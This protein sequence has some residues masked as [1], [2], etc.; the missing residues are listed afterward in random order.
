MELATSIL[1]FLRFLGIGIRPASSSGIQVFGRTI[2][3]LNSSSERS[4]SIKFRRGDAAAAFAMKL[5]PERLI[6]IGAGDLRHSI[7]FARAGI[8][9]TAVDLGSSVYAASRAPEVQKNNLKVIDA[10]F[11]RLELSERFEVLFCSH[12]LEHQQDVKAFLGK[13]LE[14]VTEGGVLIFVLPYPH[15]DLQGGHV[16]QFTPKSVIYNLAL[17]GLD[18]S[19]SLAFDSHG[20]FTVVVR[21]GGLSDVEQYDLTFDRGDVSKLSHLLPDD[22]IEGSNAYGTWNTFI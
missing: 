1:G 18:C 21:N 10:D 3:K 4:M 7:E 13:C 8:K 19:K 6:D 14:S 22:A 17:L 2:Y 16:A 5:E 11:N 15:W 12:T 20:E 9:T